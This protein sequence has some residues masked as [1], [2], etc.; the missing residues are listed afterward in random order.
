MEMAFKPAKAEDRAFLL[1][2]RKLTMT[3]HLETAGVYLSDQEHLERIDDGF[4]DIRL[5]VWQQRPIGMIKYKDTA[6]L[7]HIKQLQIL[8][9]YQ[10]QGIGK[11]V[12]EKVISEAEKGVVILSVLKQ[13]PALF[14]YQ[15]LGFQYVG[16][17]DLEFQL[18]YQ[19]KNSE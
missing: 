6:Q 10:G 5:L 3:Q 9:Q 11:W 4:A 16:E 13:N 14:L 1:K 8:P 2:L 15:R 12:V 7:S 17:D 18:R 19:A